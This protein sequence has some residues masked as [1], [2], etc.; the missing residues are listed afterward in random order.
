MTQNLDGRGSGNSQPVGGPQP[1]DLLI[2]NAY[3]VTM[4]PTRRVFADGAV[5]ISD[6]CIVDIGATTTLAPKF[7]PTRTIDAAGGLV[8][9]GFVEC[10]THATYHIERGAF[11]DTISY[12]ELTPWFDVP[13]LNAVDDDAEN[14]AAMLSSLEMV[15]NGTT[16]FLEAGTAY[17]PSAVADAANAVGIRGLV[18]DPWLWDVSDNSDGYN[19]LPLSRA[20]V[21]TDRALALLGKELQ[22]N[23][24]PDALVGAHVAI[25]G[26]GTASDELEIA[27]KQ[28]ADAAGTILNQ[29]QSYYQVD[30]ETDDRRYGKHALVHLGEIGVLGQNCTFAHMN[31]IRDDE[32]DLILQSGLSMVWCPAGSMLWGVGGTMTGRHA[33]LYKRG[34]NVAL[35]SDSANWSNSFDLGIQGYLAVLTARERYS[36]RTVLVAEDALAMATVNG[37]RA[38]GLNDRIGSLEVG[39]R[40]DLVIRANDVPE[41]FPL[42]DPVSN[43]VFS[44]R[45]KTVHTVV[46][47]GRIVFEGRQSTMVD[48][49]EV[50]AAVQT[51]VA[52][53]FDR[54]G[55]RFDPKWPALRAQAQ[56]ADLP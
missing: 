45:S 31:M 5:A 56:G 41:A 15:G 19:A 39:K 48:R 13:Y 8:H 52:R 14:A 16:C 44:A 7:I 3:V 20:P 22:R 4:D 46:I 37:A 11:G 2:R 6:H 51:S 29:H 32:V 26:M 9:P 24:H 47:D 34:V 17:E 33:E 21:S 1:V 36:D 10:H 40:A 25:Q 35:G 12:E 54:M 28:T 38:A 27:A 50:F 53:V 43:L 18:A 55:Y 42:T 30:V 49:E 23:S